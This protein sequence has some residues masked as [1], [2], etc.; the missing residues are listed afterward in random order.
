M[1]QLQTISAVLH[2]LWRFVQNGFSTDQSESAVQGAITLQQAVYYGPQRPETN[3]L[4]LLLENAYTEAE[5]VRPLQP[6]EYVTYQ[7]R[8]TGR[9]NQAETKRWSPGEWHVRLKG[10][11]GVHIGVVPMVDTVIEFVTDADDAVV[12]Y[13]LDVLDDETITFGVVGYSQPGVYEE[14][15]LTTAQW[16]ELRPVFVSIMK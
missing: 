12:G 4:R 13:V 15:T 10:K 8:T 16:H 2:D 1:L 3:I 6:S 11:T 14:L 5:I 9:I 7:L